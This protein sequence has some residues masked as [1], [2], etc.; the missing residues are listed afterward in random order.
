MFCNVLILRMLKRNWNCEDIVSRIL[1]PALGVYLCDLDLFPV[2]FL[3]QE[4]NSSKTSIQYVAYTYITNSKENYFQE[5][6]SIEDVIVIFT[7]LFR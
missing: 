4:I 7:R 2:L 5:L 6:C 1:V 3:S